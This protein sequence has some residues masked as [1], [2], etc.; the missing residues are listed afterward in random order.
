MPACKNIDEKYLRDLSWGIVVR[1]PQI[2]IEKNFHY[3]KYGSIKNTRNEAIKFRDEIYKKHFGRSI[4]KRTFHTKKRK[5]KKNTKLPELEPGL[6]Y[7]YSRG[8]LLYVVLTY[9]ED[10]EKPAQK[11]R[12]NIKKLGLEPAI[13]QART[14]LS[15]RRG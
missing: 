14:E 11:I 15:K 6:S 5:S 10:P 13:D 1:I 12:F 3:R 2:D 7:G 4:S 8:K 9:S